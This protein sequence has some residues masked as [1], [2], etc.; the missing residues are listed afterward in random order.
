[1]L[2]S[3]V[4][5]R[6]VLLFTC[7]NHRK[8]TSRNIEKSANRTWK[9]SAKICQIYRKLRIFPNRKM[10]GKT[11][12]LGKYDDLS[13]CFSFC[14][15]VCLLSFLFSVSFSVFPVSVFFYRCLFLCP[16]M[17]MTLC[18][19]ITRYFSGV[20]LRNCWLWNTRKLRTCLCLQYNLRQVS[21][22]SVSTVQSTSGQFSTDT[23][24]LI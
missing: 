3:P 24:M 10:N 15:S 23:G 14:L 12:N 8:S 21:Y 13:V 18:I 5:P 19:S 16:N 22:L 4:Y 9:K 11:S 17:A 20:I 7:R 6:L 1:M 2:A